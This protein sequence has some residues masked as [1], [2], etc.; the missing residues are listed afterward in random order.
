MKKTI[1]T[2][3]TATVNPNNCASLNTHN[4]MTTTATPA[5]NARNVIE[6]KTGYVPDVV[7]EIN[8]TI[9]RIYD[10]PETIPFSACSNLMEWIAINNIHVA[11]AH[12]AVNWQANRDGSKYACHHKNDQYTQVVAQKILS[13]ENL[14]YCM[15]DCA[16]DCFSGLQTYANEQG[17]KA[18]FTLENEV[19]SLEHDFISSGFRAVSKGMKQ[20]AS[21][22]GIHETAIETKD[23]EG[24]WVEITLS[25]TQ[26]G[27]VAQW[28]CD[29]MVADIVRNICDNLPTE[30]H[31]KW[32]LCRMSGYK[33]T[34]IQEELCI[35]RQKCRELEKVVVSIGQKIVD[36]S[37]L[38][39]YADNKQAQKDKPKG[40]YV[41]D[42][43]KTDF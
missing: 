35:S 24:K 10:K 26:L 17:E 21:V 39:E 1:N 37:D 18:C 33:K 43:M 14:V 16:M 38:W 20:N 15:D 29:I 30:D 9:K 34:E 25:P 19:V 3:A 23:N 11:I 40:V 5:I 32:L 2:T 4:T 36:Y 13:G 42:L 8:R 6:N 41:R 12:N 31:K 7:T 27:K 22:H 28:E